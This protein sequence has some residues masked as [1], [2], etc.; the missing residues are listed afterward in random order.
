[1]WG[2]VT[3]AGGFYQVDLGLVQFQF[4]CR[5][6][7]APGWGSPVFWIGLVYTCVQVSGCGFWLRLLSRW[8]RY[9]PRSL[10]FDCSV[11]LGSLVCGGW[12][13]YDP[14]HLG[15]R[16]SSVCGALSLHL[17]DG[18]TFHLLPTKACGLRSVMVAQTL[19]RSFLM[20]FC[21]HLGCGLMTLSRDFSFSSFV[22][23]GIGFTSWLRLG[24]ITSNPLHDCT[25]RFG[26]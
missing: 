18:C 3:R 6:V 9:P 4:G 5:I 16:P 17:D 14:L 1:M 12:W 24:S 22:L 8:V 2:L 23:F 21:T 25:T 26:V 10:R 7:H 19:C 11:G 13:L 15:C 20:R